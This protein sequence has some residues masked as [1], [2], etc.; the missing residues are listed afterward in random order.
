[1]RSDLDPILAELRERAASI[2]AAEPQGLLREQRD[3]LLAWADRLV[4]LASVID[5]QKPNEFTWTRENIKD[6]PST[7]A[8]SSTVAAE[9]PAIRPPQPEDE[10]TIEAV[11]QR[12]GDFSEGYQAGH[13][14]GLEGNAYDSDRAW[15][16]SRASKELAEAALRCRAPDPQ[17]ETHESAPHE[18][19][20]CPHCG[21]WVN[22]AQEAEIAKIEVPP[23]SE[24]ERPATDPPLSELPCPWCGDALNVLKPAGGCLIAERFGYSGHAEC[25]E[26]AEQAAADVAGLRHQVEQQC[27]H[28][29]NRCACA[30]TTRHEAFDW[31]CEERD[32]TKALEADVAGL[33]QQLEQRR[34]PKATEEIRLA[35][36][37]CHEWLSGATNQDTYPHEAKLI[38]R[39]V[40]ALKLAFD[41]PIMDHAE[42]TGLR[43]QLQQARKQ[44]AESAWVLA[45]AEEI[46]R[47]EHWKSAAYAF[48]QAWG[49]LPKD[50]QT[51]IPAE[52]EGA[53]LRARLQAEIS[54]LVTEMREE[55]CT[56]GDET[57]QDQIESWATKL[58]TLLQREG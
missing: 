50:L 30:I 6:Y 18:S 36:V 49:E 3:R 29:E 40:A 21:A 26:N 41:N 14:D 5:R 45:R 35:I 27:P 53:G 16:L 44:I 54:R 33:R 8:C 23:K 52:A 57:C 1:M 55:G 38:H 11:R 15:D 17:Q 25:I 58:A 28:G 31:F 13:E 9:A 34:D 42:V 12:A 48:E 24:W 37:A 19:G 22:F 47:D 39:A 7:N 46:I 4:Y 51:V 43:E 2:Y 56:W 32:K 10:P 20:N